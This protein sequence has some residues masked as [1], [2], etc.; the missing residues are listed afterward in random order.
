[1]AYAHDAIR[2]NYTRQTTATAEHI[3]KNIRKLAVFAE[4]NARQTTAIIEHI[5]TDTR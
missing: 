1:M 2:D 5:I 3:I 4:S